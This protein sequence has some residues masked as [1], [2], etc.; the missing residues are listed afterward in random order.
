MSR[1]DNQLTLWSALRG[2]PEPIELCDHQRRYQ[3]QLRDGLGWQCCRCGL[4]L[5]DDPAPQLIGDARWL[6]PKYV[7]CA[8]PR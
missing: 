8:E 6:S 3:R 2:F 4:L 1:L 5:T 7:P